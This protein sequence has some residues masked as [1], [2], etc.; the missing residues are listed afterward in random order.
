[1]Y[2]DEKVPNDKIAAECV[3]QRLRL[4]MIAALSLAPLGKWAEMKALLEEA[5]Q[6]A[7]TLANTKAVGL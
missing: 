3:E 7:D 6:Y 2:D 5:T 1:M 4:T